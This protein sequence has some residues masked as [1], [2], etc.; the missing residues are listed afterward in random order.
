MQI[1]LAEGRIRRSSEKG[2]RR[3]GSLDTASLENIVAKK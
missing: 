3:G 2:K 1:G